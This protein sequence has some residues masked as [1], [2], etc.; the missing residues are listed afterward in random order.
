[1][2]A[3]TC[4]DEV[5]EAAHE[6]A[7]RSADGSFTAEEV[8]RLIIGRGSTFAESTIRTHVVS[9]MCVDAP[10]HHAV[11]YPDLTRH[12]GGRYRLVEM[13]QRI[14]TS[15][16]PLTAGTSNTT[17]GDEEPL[18]E[19]PAGSS[20]VQRQAETAILDGLA[21]LLGYKVIPARLHLA[22]G[23][24]VDVDGVSHAPPTLVEAWAHQGPPKGG[25]KHKILADALKLI[26]VG[27]ELGGHH[28]LILCFS[29]EQAARSFQPEARTWYA[30]ALKAHHVDVLV[31]DLSAEWRE[32]I[33]IAQQRQFR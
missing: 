16:A 9:R 22:G 20:S 2:L 31:V 5:L 1:M 8:V 7:V 33:R 14:G 25:Q 29:D 28:Q 4:R 27:R 19:V 11:R 23:E 26:H 18:P 10:A 30:A 6:L 12:G 32:R 13:A 24:Y 21:D 17:R 15:V 3:R